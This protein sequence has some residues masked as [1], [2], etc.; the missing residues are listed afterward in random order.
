[1]SAVS[2]RTFEIEGLR[3]VGDELVASPSRGTVI[4]L[5]GGGQTR[6][7]WRTTARSLAVAG[8][9]SL[10]VDARGHGDS[11]RAPD[12]DYSIDALV[13]D[14]A[15]IVAA[16]ESPVLV[17]ASMG[18]LSSLVATGEG[19]IR[20]RALVLVDIA[21]RTESAG[22]KRI[23]EFMRAHAD[24]F[25]SLENVADAVAAYNPR[26]ARP[27]S[28]DGLRKNVRRGA[29]GRW[30]W[31]WDPAFLRSSESH[32]K[33]MVDRTRLLAAAAGLTVPTLL[34]RG[35]ESD[36]VSPEGAGELLSLVP[37][38]R[39]VDVAGAG[40]MVAGHDNDVFARSVIDFLAELG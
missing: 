30:Y 26:R 8:W 5:H 40:H 28:V 3:L 18:G 39:L 13:C 17:G 24:G 19:R 38:A 23:R 2:V 32:P 20:P 21:P 9:S 1:M 35:M 29:D 33:R 14:L 4:L 12:G 22:A 25:A 37:G 36:V 6:H 15:G 34:V 31:H 10:T 7:S 16:Y 11:D 27:A